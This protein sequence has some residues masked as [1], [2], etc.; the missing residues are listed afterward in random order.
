ML[1]YVCSVN[2]DIPEEVIHGPHLLLNNTDTVSTAF[3]CYSLILPTQ[4]GTNIMYESCPGYQ[5]YS[6]EFQI[7]WFS[8]IKF[9]VL[10]PKN[11]FVTFVVFVFLKLWK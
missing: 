2:R 9:H 6:S 7:E 5:M 11:T 4:R 1:L 3:T 10:I 8:L